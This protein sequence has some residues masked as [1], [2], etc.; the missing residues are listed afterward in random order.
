MTAAQREDFDGLKL[1][2]IEMADSASYE[3]IRAFAVHHTLAELLALKW[4]NLA[5]GRWTTSLYVPA[6]DLARALQPQ[7]QPA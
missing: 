5:P 4:I 2:F 3:V 1:L 6:G 7:S